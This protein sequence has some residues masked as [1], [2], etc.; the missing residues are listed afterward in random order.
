MNE[1]KEWC[2]PAITVYGDVHR[3]TLQIKFKQPG[4]SDDFNVPGISDA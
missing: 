3:I 1:K 4:L 2:T